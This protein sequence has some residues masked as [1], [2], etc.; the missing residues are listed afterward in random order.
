MSKTTGLNYIYLKKNTI[1]TNKTKTQTQNGENPDHLGAEGRPGV[2]VARKDPCA[3]C[4]LLK[5]NRRK[6]KNKKKT[7]SVYNQKQTTLYYTI[8]GES[9]L[10]L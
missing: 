9:R 7:G 6:D 8:I 5:I 1:L 10:S 3:V 2:K 4:R